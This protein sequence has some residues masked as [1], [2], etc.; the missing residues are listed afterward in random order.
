MTTG[1]ED[2]SSCTDCGQSLPLMY[3]CFQ[4]GCP[5]ER[6]KEARE[7][8]ASRGI[9][10]DDYAADGVLVWMVIDQEL[11]I[12]RCPSCNRIFKNGG[13]CVAPVMRGGC[14]MGGDF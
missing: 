3:P 12:W 5:T 4:K 14:P 1:I 11:Q 2:M 10:P 6:E 13:I 9:D 8:C 7:E